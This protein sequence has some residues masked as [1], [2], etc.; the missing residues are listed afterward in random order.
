MFY[1]F[2][3]V[4]PSPDER[5]HRPPQ[6]F[7]SFYINQLEMGL[8]FPFPRFIAELCHHIKI[9]PKHLAPNSYSFLLSL[10]ILLRYHN[11]PLVPY[12]LMQLI[13]VKRLG[14]RKFYLSHKGDHALIKGN[15]SSHK[16]WMSRFF[17]VKRVERKQDPWKCDMSWRAMDWGGGEVVKFDEAMGQHAEVV[18]RLKELEAERLKSEA[19]EEFLKSPKFNALLAKKAWGYFKDGF[20]GCLA[21]FRAHG[22]SEEEHPASFLDVQQ[23]L[24]EKSHASAR[25]GAGLSCSGGV[26]IRGGASA[27]LGLVAEWVGLV[28]WVE[29]LREWSKSTAS[30]QCGTGLS[31]EKVGPVCWR[32]RA[33][34]VA[35]AELG[36]V[37]QVGLPPEEVSVRNWAF[38]LSSG[39]HPRSLI[40]ETMS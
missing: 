12:V 9:S 10:A 23:A 11:L 4:L 6:G 5:A 29:E 32:R 1:K 38:V 17:F 33:T 28:C 3:V 8:R 40:V 25:C 7:H 14:P 2:E 27:E 36:L 34:R 16:G 39:C 19:K 21:Q 22:Y 26:A 18:A 13:K 35:S 37:A 20:W 31:F 24:A 30:D 15:P